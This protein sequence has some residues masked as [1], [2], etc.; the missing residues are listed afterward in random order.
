MKVYICRPTYRLLLY[1]VSVNY[2]TLPVQ[3]I[4]VKRFTKIKIVTKLN[5]ILYVN[6]EYLYFVFSSV[7]V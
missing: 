2:P 7:H 4:D 1:F 5:N 6:L 3:P